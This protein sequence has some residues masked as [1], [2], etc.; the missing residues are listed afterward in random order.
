L[1]KVID[2]GAVIS[3]EQRKSIADY[4]DSA[5]EEGADVFQVTIKKYT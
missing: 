1:D 5:R 3:E 2:M 4:V